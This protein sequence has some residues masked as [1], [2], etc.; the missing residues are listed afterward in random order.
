MNVSGLTFPPL[1]TDG[2]RHVFTLRTENDPC[3]LPSP[4]DL[5]ERFGFPSHRLVFAGQPHGNDVAVVSPADHGTTVPGVDA[6]AT[7]SP[8][9]TL[10]IRTADC[11][12]ILFFDP[13]QRVVAL[14]HSGKKGTALNIAARTIQTLQDTWQC[15]PQDLV[16][17]LGPCIRPPFYE[18]DFAAD[19]ARQCRQ[20]GVEHF[21]DCG[22]NTG[23]DPSRFYS[24]RMEKGRTGR[25]YT[26]ITLR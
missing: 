12:P 18:I 9:T 17:V 14:A 15:R 10:V 24:Y 8:G 1:A 13:R 21:H 19:I 6:L 23:A 20:L 16:V 25:H 22:E 5:L 26:A 7:A 11:G 4:E 2:L 3:C